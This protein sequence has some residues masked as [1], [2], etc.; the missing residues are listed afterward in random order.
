MKKNANI[1]AALCF[2]AAAVYQVAVSI[3]L[4][5]SYFDLEWLVRSGRM[6]YITAY[7]ILAVSLLKRNSLLLAAGGGL[8]VAI[9][10]VYLVDYIVRFTK[11]GAFDFESCLNLLCYYIIPLFAFTVICIYGISRMKG[12]RIC[13]FI[14]AGLYLLIISYGIYNYATSGSLTVWSYLSLLYD[15]LEMAGIAFTAF[16]T[17][18]EYNPAPDTYAS[19]EKNALQ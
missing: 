16:V 1:I 8:F 11:Y 7:T 13:L 19:I 5:I 18:P 6:M 12:C 4:V 3:R 14:A 9:D 2:A 10:A 17:E 15:L